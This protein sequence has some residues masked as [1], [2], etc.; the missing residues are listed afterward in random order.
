MRNR[1]FTLI[2]VMVALA[3]FAIVSLLAWRGLDLMTTSKARLD[4]EM[5]GWRELEMVFERLN[6]DLTQ[7][8]P[9][10]W[11]DTDGRVRSPVQGQ[12]SDS[13]ESCQLDLLRFGADQEPIHARYR[14]TKGR[15]ELEFPVFA[16]SAA[17]S[18]PAASE[19]KPNLLLEGVSACSLEFIDRSNASH[20]KWPT[21]DLADMTRP[22]GL[23]LHLTLEGRGEFARTYYLP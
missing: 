14:L 5:R 15:L 7:I 17:A 16:Y 12:M 13:G 20:K 23:R 3:V 6:M 19:Q 8:A 21:E 9:R 18:Q 2:E 10:S 11:T 1:G 22:R 4:A